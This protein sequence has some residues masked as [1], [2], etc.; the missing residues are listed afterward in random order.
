LI[1]MFFS[2]ATFYDN[3]YI[4]QSQTKRFCNITLQYLK[5]LIF[6]NKYTWVFR[7]VKRQ[8]TV[9]LID[10]INTYVIYLKGLQM[11]KNKTGK[12]EILQATTG[13]PADI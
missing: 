8:V 2:N 5:R 3:Q 10:Y 13:R 4:F 1:F 7:S 11:R 12:V 6:H 9:S